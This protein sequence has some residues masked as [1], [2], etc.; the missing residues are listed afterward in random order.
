MGV[1]G[2]L[3]NQTHPSWKETCIC[4]QQCPQAGR[5]VRDARHVGQ[6]DEPE[7][8]SVAT[9]T[10]PKPEPPSKRTPSSRR[11]YIHE[12]YGMDCFA[13]DTGLEVAALD[14]EPGIYS[15]R[16]A[17]GAGH[18]SVANMKKLLSRM[19]GVTDRRARF[20]TVIALILDGEVHEF[21]GIV[22]GTMLRNHTATE[23]SATTRS[24]SPKATTAPCRT[25]RR[26]EPHQPPCACRGA[27]GGVPA[28][29]LTLHPASAL[30]DI[31]CQ[32]TCHSA[33]T[34]AVEKTQNG[35]TPSCVPLSINPRD[36][37]SGSPRQTQTYH[38]VERRN[39]PVT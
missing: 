28:E 23:V 38:D 4:H 30:I 14:G 36:G 35:R 15:A 11:R 39:Q 12:H 22:R 34:I 21:E 3:F 1:C 32:Q 19:E 13:D 16:Y 2:F 18:D 29:G 26:E 7:R 17:G 20:R 6:P 8:S 25:G 9:P 27:S 24:S 10:S 37:P 31:P 5:G 33:R